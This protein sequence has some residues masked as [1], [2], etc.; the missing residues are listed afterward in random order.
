MARRS[1]EEFI[2][3]PVPWFWW[4][5]AI[6]LSVVF[7]VTSWIGCLYIF[8]H[9]EDPNNYRILKKL[10]RL[11][12]FT[13]FTPLT[14]PSGSLLAADTASSKLLALDAKQRKTLNG[15]FKK[16]IITNFK[17]PK[18]VHYIA[19]SFLITEVRK[20]TDEDFITQG[21]A[22]RARAYVRPNQY[23][24]PSA[25]PVVIEYLFP[26]DDENAINVFNTGDMLEIS[27]VPYCASI[28]HISDYSEKGE[29]VL[30]LTI[31]PLSF[32]KYKNKKSGTFT[33]S[34]PSF[35]N[36]DATFPV[37]EKHR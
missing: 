8:G 35:F 14:A 22:A 27:K 21:F 2:P 33:L 37:F 18:F 12:E 19:G 13:A 10:N 15:E 34:P 7:A 6:I 1:K 20:L 4:F 16:N 5:C 28:A 26:C 23:S 32:T 11:P 3:P 31:M 17:D 25:W 29:K 9:P 24:P 36:I 30:C